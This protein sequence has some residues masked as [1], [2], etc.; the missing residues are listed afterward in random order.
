MSIITKRGDAGRTDLLFNKKAEK[1]SPRIECLGAV[2]ELNAHLG[3]ARV[4]A[5]DEQLT[6][7]IDGVQQAL[8]NLMGEV[9]TEPA[10]LPKYIEKGYGMIQTAEVEGLEALA[11]AQ[12]KTGNTFRGWVRP[13]KDD[14][15]LTAQLHVCRTV[16]RRAERRCWALEME[17]RLVCLYLNRLA[18]V[19]WLIGNPV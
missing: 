17:S 16:C 11:A 8:I 18:D 5:S 1:T 14:S 10:D 6:E 7:W 4:H 15:M 19:L 12:E 13:G 3:L 9:A 2:D